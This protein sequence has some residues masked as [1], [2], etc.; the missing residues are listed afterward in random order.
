MKS[1]DC[2]LRCWECDDFCEIK[3]SF[4]NPLFPLI[5]MDFY[6]TSIG[7]N[8]ALY[9]KEHFEEIERDVKLYVVA[10]KISRDICIGKL[11]KPEN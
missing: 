11:P 4:S 8:L 1:F 6:K 10:L 3:E 7:A 2:S 5:L 9:G